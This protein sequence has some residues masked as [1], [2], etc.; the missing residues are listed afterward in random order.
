MIAREELKGPRAVDTL[1]FNNCLKF[2]IAFLMKFAGAAEAL[3][4]VILEN[5]TDLQKTTR[6]KKFGKG[7]NIAYS[8][9][10]D[11]CSKDVDASFVAGSHI[12]YGQTDYSNV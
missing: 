5:E 11:A 9:L 3:M 7:N 6:V 1:N 10:M 8:H 4:E 2:F 12:E